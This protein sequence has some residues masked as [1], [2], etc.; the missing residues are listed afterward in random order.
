MKSKIRMNVPYFQAPN[1]IFDQDLTEHELLIYLYLCRCGNNG[2]QAFPSYQTIAEKCKISRSVAIRTIKTLAEK[3]LIA[4]QKRPKSNNDNET[5]IYIVMTPSVRD[6]PASAPDTLPSVTNTLAPSVTEELPSVTNTPNKEIPYKE[7]DIEK[8]IDIKNQEEEPASFSLFN[9]LL[10]IWTRQYMM[11]I[12]KEAKPT[13][14]ELILLKNVADSGV[15]EMGF[16]ETVKGYFA[17]KRFMYRLGEL[18]E[19]G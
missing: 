4:K 5:N 1:S 12:G 19:A 3:K 6:T 17:K 10:G 2:G 8:E 7:I 13:E 14:E 9:S 18:L 16:Q 11:K 15:S